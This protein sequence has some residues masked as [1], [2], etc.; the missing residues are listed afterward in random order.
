MTESFQFYVAADVDVKKSE[1]EGKRLI[2]GYASTPAEDRQGE[3]LIQKGLDITNFV[4]HGWFNYD[5]NNDIILGYPTENTH[6]DDKGL[7][8]EGELLKG[9][10]MADQIWDV[11]LALKKSNAPRKL[12]F[13]VEGKVTERKGSTIVKAKIYNCAITPNPVNTEATWDAVVKSFRPEDDT[14]VSKALE[15]GYA[16][17]PETQVDGGA[18]RKESLEGSLKVL[19]ENLDNHNYWE[20]VKRN[21]ANGDT[22]TKADMVVYLQLSKGLSRQQALD[23]INN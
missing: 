15:A 14:V 2:Q 13:S 6:I 12:G 11:A 19:A 5:H 10:P 18:L 20:Q 16:T 21:L 7:W 23:V 22:A 3:S 1:Q 9:I 8:V 4:Q 17:T